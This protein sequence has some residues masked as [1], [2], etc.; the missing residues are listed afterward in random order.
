MVGIATHD[1]CASSDAEP[2]RPD[3]AGGGTRLHTIGMASGRRRSCLSRVL[4][5]A[6]FAS[7]GAAIGS[8][9]FDTQARSG[10][11]GL[12]VQLRAGVVTFTV[13][14]S[15]GGGGAG[16]RRGWNFNALTLPAGPVIVPPPVD[17]GT[18]TVFYAH[19]R[20]NGFGIVLTSVSF[21]LLQPTLVLVA[22][23]T[24]LSLSARRARRQAA[25]V[26]HCPRCGYDTAG[27]S[28]GVPCPECGTP[29][30]P[31]QGGNTLEPQSKTG[32]S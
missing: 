19:K 1:D 24:V 18:S 28:P 6:A 12:W 14:E 23:A 8:R 21:A 3:A 22:A 10:V 5:V 2:P 13:V 29:A 20:L 15:I 27:L 17:F 25:R 16:T 11:P 4:F 32:V 26:G 7:F 9:W 31:G 30:G